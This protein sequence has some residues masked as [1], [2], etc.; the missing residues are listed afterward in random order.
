MILGSCNMRKTKKPPLTADLQRKRMLETPIA[1]LVTAM[2]IPGM[3]SQLVTV[4]YNMADTYFVAQI[5]TSA[6]AAI[7]VVFSLQSIVQA[8]GFGLGT[9]V[10]SLVSRCLGAKEDDLAACYANSSI[11]AGFVLGMAVL[12]FGLVFLEELMILLGSTPTMLDYSMTYAKWILLSAPFLCMSCVLNMI[13]RS[14]G[15]PMLAMIGIATGGVL[16]AVMDPIL[17]F[18]YG[19]GIFG[20][21]L[22]T[23]I[24]QVVSF[25]LLLGMFLAGKSVLPLR[26]QAVSR[27]WKIYYD[28]I[29]T[30]VPTISRQGMASV[31]TALLTIG[32][33]R[34]GDAVVAAIT[35]SNKIYLFVRNLV[36]GVGQGFQ[37]VAGYNFGAKRF[38]RTRAS[39]IFATKAGT[40]IC[41]VAALLIGWQ[42]EVVIG[43]FRNDPEVI[44]VGKQAL[45]YACVVM[46]FLAFSTYVNQLYQ[47]LGFKVQA[48]LL[49][50]CRNGFFLIPVLAVL[51]HFF[52]MTGIMAAQ[53]VADFLTFVISIPFLIG[54]FK[55]KLHI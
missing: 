54:F 28:I 5:G 49:A 14:E 43:W 38:E 8:F 39:F 9:G 52:G 19:M 33:S 37:P 18:N 26:M 22:S 48:T 55:W 34:Y 11:F 7:G 16:N 45:W 4:I 24:S 36:L 6:A 20:A 42:A 32:A 13:L 27:R 3:I 46:P 15:E 50:C 23:F 44:A 12:C 30:G 40:A 10:G 17:I 41:V 29:T 47:C 53:P 35:I 21:A 25:L 1:P 51:P 2:A 31:G